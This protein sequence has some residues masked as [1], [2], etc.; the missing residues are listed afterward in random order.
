[1]YHN[2]Y[3]RLQSEVFDMSSLEKK[4]ICLEYF[5]EAHKTVKYVN[6]GGLLQV[7]LAWLPFYEN[8]L[9]KP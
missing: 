6:Y 9:P 8:L 5:L 7:L 2:K 3:L 4:S 1:M